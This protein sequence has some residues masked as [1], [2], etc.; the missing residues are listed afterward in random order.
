MR[1]TQLGLGCGSTGVMLK[2]SLVL[3]SVARTGFS[4]SRTF[5]SDGLGGITMA[6]RFKMFSVVAET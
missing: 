1:W 2:R 3:H 5:C 6:L 4:G